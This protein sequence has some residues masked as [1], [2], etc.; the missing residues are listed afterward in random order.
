MSNAVAK[1][2]ENMAVATSA[3][4]QLKGLIAS[5]VIIPQLLLMQGMS[6]FVTGGKATPGQVVKNT[7][8]EVM[9]N[10]S[11]KLEFIPLSLPQPSWIIEV[12]APKAQR[13]EFRRRV[14]RTASNETLP[15]DFPADAEGNE[16]VENSKDH[17]H[18]GRRV[19]CLTL[20]AIL[21]RDIDSEAAEMKKAQAGELPDISK[22]LTPVLISFRS[23]G[24]NAGKEVVTF[25]TQVEAFGMQAY[26][27]ILQLGCHQESNDRGTFFVYDVDRVKPSAVKKEH[28]PKVEHWAGIV[29]SQ[30]ANLRIDE[31][32]DVEAEAPVVA[33]GG[34][35][36]F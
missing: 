31:T 34:K 24:F 27:Y 26:K 21:P 32:T 25:F 4:P 30:A 8:L 6:D 28:L 2:E 16:V 23:T 13:F 12:K 17:T 22:A 36:L 9:G 11:S 1:R 20:F 14:P 10:P 29:N 33:A 15:W 35:K 18:Q 19:K 5:D 7:T 3:P